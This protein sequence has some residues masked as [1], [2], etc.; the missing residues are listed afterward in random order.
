MT[1]IIPSSTATIPTIISS[2]G[3]P[4][5]KKFYYS[6]VSYLATLFYS[7]KSLDNTKQKI[8]EEIMQEYTPAELIISS[9]KKKH[10]WYPSISNNLFFLSKGKLCITLDKYEKSFFNFHF[11]NISIL[12]S[13]SDEEKN[14]LLD[15][16]ISFYEKEVK[17]NRQNFIK[18]LKESL[19]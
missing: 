1:K 11:N 6:I 16:V 13:F 14:K 18:D 3:M 15:I 9:L 17:I 12:E 2:K 7:K 19:A 10:G 8:E 4:W 5:Y